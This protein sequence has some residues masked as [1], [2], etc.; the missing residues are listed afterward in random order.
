MTI[1]GILSKQIKKQAKNERISQRYAA[2]RLP[3]L[4]NPPF[5]EAS[6]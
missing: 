2:L 3:L 4:S 1:D 6:L 5:S